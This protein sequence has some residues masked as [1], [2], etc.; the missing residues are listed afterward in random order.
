[1]KNGGNGQRL[2][3]LG[4]HANLGNSAAHAQGTQRAGQRSHAAHFD[5]QVDAFAA[6]LVHRPAVPVGV[7]LVVEAGVEPEGASTVKLRIARGDSEHAQSVKTGKLDGK[8]GDAAGSLDED[9]GPRLQVGGG[10]RVPGRDGGAGQR[11]SFL[12]AE[13]VGNADQAGLLE[14][15]VIGERAVDVTSQRALDLGRAG[16]AVEPVLHENADDAVTGLPEGHALTDSCNF[17]GAVGAGDAG[18]GQFRV[19]EALDHEQIAV[20][21]RNRTHMDKDFSGA[22]R[23]AGTLDKL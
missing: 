17:A 3:G 7:F 16:W 4:Q 23:G 2:F 12:K 6:G 5:H 10:E 15:D 8:D 19:V 18:K 1:M 13:V 21:E 14:Q 20:I 22:R 9:G 11:G